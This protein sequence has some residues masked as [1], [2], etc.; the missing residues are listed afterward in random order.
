MTAAER[1]AQRA[2]DRLVAVALLA[3]ICG[4]A[5]VGVVGVL[6]GWTLALLPAR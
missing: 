3:V 5:V 6:L 4:F 1:A 2:S